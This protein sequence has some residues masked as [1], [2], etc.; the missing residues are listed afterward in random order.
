MQAQ[1]S[2]SFEERGYVAKKIS[3]ECSLQ[4]VIP[5]LANI[6]GRAF[7]SLASTHVSNPQQ[8]S[9]LVS[10]SLPGSGISIYLSSRAAMRHERGRYF[11]SAAHILTVVGT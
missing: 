3:S 7:V 1:T 4:V 8:K 9:A 10:T 5:E 2:A 6:L 11:T